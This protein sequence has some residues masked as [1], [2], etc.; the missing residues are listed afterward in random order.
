M[1]EPVLGFT[2]ENDRRSRCQR[3]IRIVNTLDKI[4]GIYLRV[5]I[6]FTQVFADFL[7]CLVLFPAF[8]QCFAYFLSGVRPALRSFFRVRQIFTISARDPIVVGHLTVTGQQS[9][10]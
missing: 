7:S 5:I 6:L 3:Q 10:H 1:L 2:L 8:P 4:F 9:I